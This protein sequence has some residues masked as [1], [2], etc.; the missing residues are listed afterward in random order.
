MG[1]VGRHGQKRRRSKETPILRMDEI[2][3]GEYKSA[4]T[5]IYYRN[6]YH[7]TFISETSISPRMT[8]EQDVA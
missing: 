2:G 3:E 4:C 1:R 6:V 5:K 8:I 7:S